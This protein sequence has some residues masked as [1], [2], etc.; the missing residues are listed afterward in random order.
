M[1]FKTILKKTC[2]IDWKRREQ[3]YLPLRTVFRVLLLKTTR[4]PQLGGPPEPPSPA[5]CPLASPGYTTMPPGT[6]LPAVPR[7]ERLPAPGSLGHSPPAAVHSS[8]THCPPP[9]SAAA[10]TPPASAPAPAAAPSPSPPLC[11][12]LFAR[13]ALLSPS[14]RGSVRAKRCLGCPPHA[15]ACIPRCIAARGPRCWEGSSPLGEQFCCQD[16]ALNPPLSDD[17]SS[18][19]LILLPAGTPGAARRRGGCGWAPAAGRCCDPG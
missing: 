3:F 6:F 5:R 18:L 2:M 15:P 4:D 17:F 13:A 14:H 9:R 10:P 11:A 8:D 16:G 19:P 1:G 7:G 12:G